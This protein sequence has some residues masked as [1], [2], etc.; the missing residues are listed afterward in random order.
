M[1]FYLSFY[2]PVTLAIV[3]VVVL[4]SLALVWV[5]GVGTEDVWNEANS[6]WVLK[7]VQVVAA[8]VFV[9][10]VLLT[11]AVFGLGTVFTILSSSS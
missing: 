6:G 3:G 1:S 4:V 5:T 9:A 8:V 11:V 7:A 10:L 2:A